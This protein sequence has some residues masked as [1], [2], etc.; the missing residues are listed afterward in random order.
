MNTKLRYSLATV[1]C[2]LMF[3]L[4]AGPLAGQAPTG[5]LRGTVLDASGARISG[6]LVTITDDATATQYT[7]QT[8]STGD[9][10]T[11]NCNAG[12]STVTITK[13]HFRT[14]LSQHLH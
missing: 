13:P 5:T 11:V 8:G 14:T 2:S 4:V 7:T 1:L 12:P 10:L 3:G 6:A 9:F